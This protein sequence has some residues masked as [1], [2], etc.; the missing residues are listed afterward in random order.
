M[1]EYLTG[2]GAKWGILGGI[3]AKLLIRLGVVTPNL[4]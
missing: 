4:L 2:N 3:W 1:G